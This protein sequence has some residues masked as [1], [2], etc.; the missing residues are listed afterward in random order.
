MYIDYL[1]CLSYHIISYFP[2]EST[3][4]M[5]DEWQ[6]LL[7]PFDTAMLDAAEYFAEFLPTVLAV[8]Q[9][10]FGYRLWFDKFV[11]LWLDIRNQSPLNDVIG[12]TS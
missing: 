9:H 7:C 1:P 12:C 2:V 4:E 5:L 6:P 3:Q 8:N 11:E 10:Q